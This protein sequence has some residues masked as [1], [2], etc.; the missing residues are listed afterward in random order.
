LL[1]K[2]GQ[3]VLFSKLLSF[4]SYHLTISQLAIRVGKISVM[5]PSPSIINPVPVSSPGDL[6][7]AAAICPYVI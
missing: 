5:A 6:P 7:D 4:I 3:D 1:V 2:E